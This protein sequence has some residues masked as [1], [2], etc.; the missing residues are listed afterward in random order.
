MKVAALAAN[1]SNDTL[2]ADD[3]GEIA[4]L[5]PQF[6]PRR[7]D[8]FD[9]TKPVDGSDPAT[10]WRGMTPLDDNPHMV[11]PPLGWI[12]NTN[13]GPWWGAGPDSPQ[14]GGL[15][16]IHGQP[17]RECRAAGMPPGC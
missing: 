15:S 12:Y 7:D 14:T 11:N 9:Y 10:D 5:L 16:Q 6:N 3:K 1:S 13:D 8:R 2:F 4:L 17:G